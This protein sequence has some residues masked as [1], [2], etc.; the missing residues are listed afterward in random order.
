MIS[1]TDL[2]ATFSVFDEDRNGTIDREEFKKLLDHITE[3]K[4][5]KYGYFEKYKNEESNL[6]TAE[7]LLKFMIEVQKD[8]NHSL[9]TCEDL[10]KKICHKRSNSDTHLGM[11]LLMF[12]DF[13]FYSP[14]NSCL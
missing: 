10:L 12:T 1:D 13:I 2:K 5:I 4:E 3:R 7:G 11:S 9:R 8:H 6:I 14:E